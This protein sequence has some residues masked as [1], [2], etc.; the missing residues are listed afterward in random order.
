EV[1]HAGFFLD[2][3]LEAMGAEHKKRIRLGIAKPE[4]TLPVQFLAQGREQAP[5]VDR[6]TLMEAQEVYKN[7]QTPRLVGGEIGT[8][9][10]DPQETSPP[11]LVIQPPP[12]PGG[13]EAA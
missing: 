1:A 11:L 12:V 3:I 8:A 13:A 5:G 4:D 10:Y 7:P 2:E 6:S 9:S